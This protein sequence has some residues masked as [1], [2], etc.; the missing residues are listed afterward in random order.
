MVEVVDYERRH[1]DA[2]VALC[3]EEG[4]PSFPE[5]PSRADRVLRAPGVTS[6]VAVDGDEVLGFA[7]LQSDG[8]IQA[9]LSNIVV[10]RSHR[11]TGIGRALLQ[12]GLDRAGGQRLDLITDSA[13]SFY[14][15]FDHRRL[16]GY[17]LYPPFEERGRSQP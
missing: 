2:V 7:Y 3:R 13:E 15:A 17:R 10:A 16:T 4:W 8:E 9:H 11:R 5:D 1:L 6:V 14:E 12:A